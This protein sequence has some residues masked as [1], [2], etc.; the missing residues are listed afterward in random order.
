MIAKTKIHAVLTDL[1]QLMQAKNLSLAVAESASGGLLSAILTSKAG[2]SNWFLGGVCAYSNLAKINILKINPLDLEKY[3]S[4]S[5]EITTS[6]G[7]AIK[8]QLSASHAIAITGEAGPSTSQKSY[9]IGTIFISIIS[10]MTIKKM[11]LSLTGSRV[12]IQE[13]AALIAC[14]ALVEMLNN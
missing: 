12:E 11:H 6:L 5:P 8:T 7:L 10:S 3:G 2:A 9:P 13:E 1:H 14:L 4:I